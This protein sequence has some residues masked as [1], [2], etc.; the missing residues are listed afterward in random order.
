MDDKQLVSVETLYGASQ[1]FQYDEAS[2][3]TGLVW[4]NG[5]RLTIRYDETGRVREL[6]GPGTQRFGLNW[7]NGL[8]ISDARGRS[9]RIST[10]DTGPNRSVTVT[11]PMGRTVTSR[12]RK[13]DDDWVLTGWTDPRG[14]ETRVGSFGSRMDVTAP[15][16][17]VFRM[18][19]TENGEVASAAEPGGRKWRW[20]RDEE[21]R[22]VR[23]FDPGGRSTRIEYDGPV[24][25]LW[26]HPPA[27]PADSS[28]WSGPCGGHSGCIGRTHAVCPRFQW[29][30]S[31]H[32]RCAGQLVVYRTGPKRMALGR[33]ESCGCP[34]DIGVMDSLGK[35]SVVEGP[36]GRIITLHRDGAGL[37]ERIEDNVHGSVSFSR[38]ADGE[39]VKVSD[40][41][42]NDAIR[43]RWHRSRA[44]HH[45][46]R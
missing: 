3:L 39:L 44:H 11:D 16:G 4:A 34:L 19:L 26:W 8:Q 22:V 21:G 20:E 14:L 35:P 30:D 42:A 18:E 5:G 6:V 2:R 43:S 40:A 9:T 27:D 37:L 41:R 25:R 29:S 10:L 45:P 24:S 38:N 33:V 28:G 17:R 46:G 23:M 15:G 12:Y 7:A 36:M 31:K 1:Q 13:R 32:H